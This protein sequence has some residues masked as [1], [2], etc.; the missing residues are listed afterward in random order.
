VR[1]RF[2]GSGSSVSLADALIGDRLQF[3]L[4]FFLPHVFARSNHS[5]VVRRLMLQNIWVVTIE[6]SEQVIRSCKL[7]V[8]DQV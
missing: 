6:V 2:E 8:A 5:D 3:D 1:G 7:R 4:K